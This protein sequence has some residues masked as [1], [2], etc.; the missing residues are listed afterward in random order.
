MIK[1]KFDNYQFIGQFVMTG[2]LILCVF[3]FY[4]AH[5][6]KHPIPQFSGLGL[7][8]T[9]L[10]VILPLYIIAQMKLNYKTTVIDPDSKTISF[11]MFLLPITKTY[12]FNYFDGYAD[13]V[14]KDKYGSYKCFYLVKEHKLKYKMS[15]RFYSNIDELKEGISVL[16]YMGFIKNTF[17]LSMKIAFNKSVF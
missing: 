6:G 8:S 4:A 2:L 13:T 3:L 14:V 10:T 12:P 16:K 7:L 5:F 9:L 15:G 11:K 1:S 17:P